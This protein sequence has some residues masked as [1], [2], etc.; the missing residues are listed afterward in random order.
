MQVL[1]IFD[2]YAQDQEIKK[3][4]ETTMEV[5]YINEEEDDDDDEFKPR[6]RRRSGNSEKTFQEKQSMVIQLF[7]STAEGKPVRLQV[8]GFQPFFFLRLDDEPSSFDKCKRR[9]LALFDERKI[10]Y[11]CVKFE[12][13]KKKVLYGYTAGREFTFMQMNFKNLSVFRAVKK[14]VLDDHQRPIFVLYKGEKPLEVYDANL[15]PMLRFFHLRKLQPCGWIKAEVNLEEEDDVLVGQCEWD[16]IDPELA[17]PKASAPFLMAS[18]DIECYSESGD[19]PLPTRKEKMAKLGD[20]VNASQVQGDPVIQIGIVL[21]R[22]DAETERHI[23]VLGSC[24]SLKEKGIEVHVAKTEKALLLNF[25]NWLVS[26]NPD[27][28][29]GYNTFGFDEKYVWKRAMELGITNDAGFQGLSRLSALG[30]ETKLDEKFLS[31][32]ALG[33]NFLY[34]WST[35]GRL[36]IDLLHYV[37][38]GT[39]LPSYKL[40]DVCLYYMSGKLSGV[41]RKESSWLLKTKSTG[42]AKPG[43]YIVLLEE[44]GEDITEKAEVIEVIPGKGIIIK[45]PQHS[46]DIDVREAVKWAIVKDDVPPAEIFR[47]HR[48]GGPTGRAKVAAYC[49]QDCDLVVEL[50]KKLDVFNN[51]MSMANVCS[52]PVSYIFTRGQGI[53]IESLIFKECYELG[54]LV[55]ALESTPFGSTAAST[56]QEESYEGAIVLD[57][58]PGF[59]NVSP[60]GVCDFA[61]L[62]PSTIISEN[63]SYD[64]LVWVK[65]FDLDGNIVKTTMLGDESQAPPGTTWNAIEFATW[66]VKEGDTRK[67]PEKVKKGVRVCCYA[68][69]PDGSKSTLPNIVAKLLAKRK[70]K[71]KEAEK[72]N[73]QFKKALLDAEQLAYKLTANSLYGQLGSPTFK[74]RMQN[75]AASV[76]SYGRTQ[77][78]HAKNAILEFYGA[79]PKNF[80]APPSSFETKEVRDKNGIVV[81]QAMNADE[82]AYIKSLNAAEY[83]LKELAWADLKSSHDVKRTHGFIA[84]KAGKG[85]V[86]LD[87]C[88]SEA[89]GAEIVY[90]DT[91]SLFVNFNV[92]ASS[93]ARKAIVDTIELTENAGKFVTQNLKSPHD[94]EYDKVFYPFIIFS[95]KRYVGNK[96][97]ESPDDFKQTSMGIVLKRRDNAP[98]LK[99]IYGGAI[100]ILLNERNFLKAVEF[101]REKSIELVTGKTSTYQLT[102]TKSLRATYKTTP[103]PHKILAD[104]MKERDPG[105]APSAGERIGYIYISPPP[106]Q[107]APSLQGERIETPDYMKANN[108]VPD[109]RYYI[110]HQLMNPL[111]QLFAL[112]VEDIPGYQPSSGTMSPEQKESVTSDLLFGDA[113]KACD[114]S[115]VRAFGQKMFGSISVSSSENKRSPRLASAT[116]TAAVKPPPKQITLTGFLVPQEP[117]SFA[118]TK[119][120]LEE[121]AREKEKKKKSVSPPPVPKG[122]KGE[123]AKRAKKTTGVKV[124]A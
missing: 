9:F 124:D 113:L 50:Y 12:K 108:L 3:E 70:S 51:A 112:R 86:H 100:Q 11:S 40:D 88:P 99:T 18:W 41:E 68:Q 20:G 35:H 44:T 5:E 95:K 57:P 80:P 77:I 27:I 114:R 93:D 8:N 109:V 61:S 54:M 101:V 39:P 81:R 122:E 119:A 85:G 110:E 60:I 16:Q 67:Q 53:K 62:Y 123:K 117:Q 59:Y 56:G 74:I 107:L 102:I 106:G 25:A 120:L 73:D 79:G 7:G 89:G 90:G 48:E 34:I 22:Q 46:E 42:D 24:D 19:F 115:A 96:Y 69:P 23:F 78:I 111:S 49:I 66:G 97:E 76:T 64:S 2:S 14:L 82:V 83:R 29:V 118:S 94:F 13:T 21:V 103:P 92:D 1:H 121:I 26:R 10:P 72:E 63:I 104:R 37:R 84:W 52:V 36:Q 87:E 105:N 33:D 71:R 55:P 98:L 38:R 31:S 15:D 47:L 91:D 65:E 28:L 6:W 45:T 58:T 43:R 4:D 75:L 116:V 32:S 17:P 30:K